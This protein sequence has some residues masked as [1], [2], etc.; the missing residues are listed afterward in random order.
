MKIDNN[1]RYKL[2]KYRQHGV[3]GEILKA[4]QPSDKYM[5]KLSEIAKANG[6]KKCNSKVTGTCKKL[7]RKNPSKAYMCLARIFFNLETKNPAPQ[8]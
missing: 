4:P 8:Q 2:I 7:P 5:E 6:V 1:I 3:R